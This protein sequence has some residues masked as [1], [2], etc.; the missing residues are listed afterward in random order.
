MEE[1][2]CLRN[3][4]LAS[5]IMKEAVSEVPEVFL[6]ASANDSLADANDSPDDCT[7][8]PDEARDAPDDNIDM[9]DPGLTG[10]RIW[11][12]VEEQF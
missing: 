3:A 7:D 10:T 5:L 6:D 8:T 4:C 12:K 9:D 1:E 11:D 2:S